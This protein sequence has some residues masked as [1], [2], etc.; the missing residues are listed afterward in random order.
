MV[1]AQLLGIFKTVRTIGSAMSGV[2]GMQATTLGATGVSGVALI[3]AIYYGRTMYDNLMHRLDRLEDRI[4]KDIN[5]RHDDLNIKVDTYH[6]TDVKT[7]ERMLVSG[8][9]YQMRQMQHIQSRAE[10]NVETENV[11]KSSDS[12]NDNECDNDRVE[13]MDKNIK[14]IRSDVKYIKKKVKHIH[15]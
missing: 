8:P 7:Y 15:K 6:E 14:K 3:I 4:S 10:S 1:L 13:E 12:S 9:Q 2:T 5:D 11:S